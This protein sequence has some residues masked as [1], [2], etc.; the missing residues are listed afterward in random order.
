VNGGEVEDVE[1]HGGDAL[2]PFH[3][4]A[5]RPGHPATGLLVEIRPLRPREHLVPAARLREAP[6]DLQRVG[7]RGRDH[8]AQRVGGQHPDHVLGQ[9]GGEAV[10]RVARGVPKDRR[11]GPQHGSG[12]VG[13]LAVGGAGEEPRSLRQHQFDVHPGVDLDRGVVHPRGV[14]VG[15]ALDPE[16]PQARGVGAEPCL[17]A[18][19]ALRHVLHGGPGMVAS[20]GGDEDG[21]GRDGVVAF[22]E[23]GGPDGE[24]LA[25]RSLG[26]PRPVLD[27]GKHL[28]DGDPA[29]LACRHGGRGRERTRCAHKCKLTVD[30][31]R[32]QGVR[33]RFLAAGGSVAGA[34]GDVSSI[35]Y[36]C[37]R[38]CTRR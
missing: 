11:R 8:V 14:G 18:V 29:D 16:P 6:V 31:P 35:T 19:K 13:Q 26:G 9:P 27:D 28:G 5:E 2:D 24:R 34:P 25:D 15:P 23:H 38:R 33:D 10:S 36:P 30:P 21:R 1:A 17:V 22:P 20:V 7:H 4:R 32:A 37:G 12:V 3:R